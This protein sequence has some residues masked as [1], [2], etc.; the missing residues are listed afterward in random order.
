MQYQKVNIINSLTKQFKI[1]ILFTLAIV[2]SITSLATLITTPVMADANNVVDVNFNQL[3]FDYSKT[4]NIVG[5]GKNDGDQVL[6][7]DLIT[8]D[9]VTVD[10]LVSTTLDAGVSVY[11]YGSGGAGAPGDFQVNT[12]IATANN[13]AH[14]SFTFF[15][16]GSYPFNPVAL[17]LENVQITAKD[18]DARQSNS[19]SGIWGYTTSNS[20]RLVVTQTTPGFWPTD[21]MFSSGIGGGVDAPED[22]AVASYGLVTTTTIAMSRSIGNAL[23]QQFFALTWKYASFGTST[24]TSFGQPSTITYNL[25][26]GTG[27]T[28]TQVSGVF[29]EQKGT[30]AD[31]TGF[32]NPGYTF[33]GWST[34]ANGNA[35]DYLAGSVLTMPSLDTTLYAMWSCDVNPDTSQTG[36]TSLKPIPCLK[37]AD[38]PTEPATTNTTPPSITAPDT[39]TTTNTQSLILTTLGLLIL[40]TLASYTIYKT[41]SKT[42]R[43]K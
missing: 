14:F 41:R 35:K 27:T 13:S 17:T 24:T 6:W 8:V 4:Q 33:L 11:S 36:G 1:T 2:L 34:Q 43:A 18:I 31:S 32:T 30:V 20:T 16:S 3:Y 39:G 42:Y 5:D 12:I 40:I 21:V 37:P 15:R 29:G 26:G 25:N 10:A 38:P 7:K 22:Q 19:F 23:T 9:G 28:P